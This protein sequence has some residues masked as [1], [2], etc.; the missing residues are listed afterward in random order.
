MAISSG[1]GSSALLPAGLGFRNKIINGDFRIAQRGDSV[2]TGVYTLDRWVVVGTGTVTKTAF[3]SGSS[4]L[5]GVEASSYLNWTITSNQQNAEML[6]RV[7]DV[8][9]CAGQTVTL[10]FWARSTAGA[11]LCN[12]NIYQYYGTGGSSLTTTGVNGTFTPTSTWTKYVFT[13][14]IPSIAGKTIG[15]DSY[16]WVRVAQLTAT[17]TNTSLDIWGVQLEANYQ[18]TPFE[19]RP[20]GTELALCQRYYWRTQAGRNNSSTGII[21][22]YVGVAADQNTWVRYAVPYP[23]PMRTQPAFNSGGSFTNLLA[24]GGYGA[25]SVAAYITSELSGSV[26]LYSS[27]I[28]LGASG[29]MR[30]NNTSTFIDFS[31]EL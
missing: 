4:S 16:L 22:A 1:L 9:T 19:Q 14:V 15:T 23:V 11:Q 12:T 30:L 17:T 26:Y 29:S 28:S 7:E 24:G 2:A 10:S 3:A 5:V 25:S 18:P 6:Q 31:A 13:G 8:R 20:I 27:G 21:D